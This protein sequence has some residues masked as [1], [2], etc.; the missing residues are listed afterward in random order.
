MYESSVRPGVHHLTPGGRYSKDIEGLRP[1]ADRW[2]GRLPRAA[3]GPAQLRKVRP[4][5][6]RSE[7]IPHACRHAARPDHRTGHRPVHHRRRIRRARTRSRPRSCI[8]GRHQAGG[9]EHRRRRL[10]GSFVGLLHLVPSIL[11]V[12]GL[13][14][15]PAAGRR[16]EGTSP[17]TGNSDRIWPWTPTNSCGSSL[18]WLNAFVPKPGLRRY[19]VSMTSCSATSR[20]PR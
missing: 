12:R 19:P 14:I 3:V 8:P 7:R 9:V 2:S 1:L 15:R 6:L 5:V 11:A 20:F 18:R 17:R 10:D 13:G 16:V 4:A